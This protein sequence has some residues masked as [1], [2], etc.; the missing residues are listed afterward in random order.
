MDNSLKKQI[1]FTQTALDATKKF[2]GTKGSR[3]LKSRSCEMIETLY[4]QMIY[5]R[6]ELKE[7]FN[8]EEVKQCSNI[9][10]GSMYPNVPMPKVFFNSMFENYELINTPNES[11]NT[12][13]DKVSNLTNFQCYVLINMCHEYYASGKVTF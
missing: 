2:I 1:Q 4:Y 8:E 9:L 10:K 7:I 13:K 3:D 12:I 6:K 11:F 5:T